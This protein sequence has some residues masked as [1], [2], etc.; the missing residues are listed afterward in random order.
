MKNNKILLLA[1]LLHI[2]PD[3]ATRPAMPEEHLS[4]GGEFSRGHR[5]R[6]EM[7]YK[8]SKELSEKESENFQKRE[9]LR[10]EQAKEKQDPNSEIKNAVKE[11]L[12]SIDSEKLSPEEIQASLKKEFNVTI[13]LSAADTPSIAATQ[14]EV[15][16]HG[17]DKRALKKEHDKAENDMKEAHSA[18]KDEFEKTLADINKTKSSED[19]IKNTT[20]EQADLDKF[21]KTEVKERLAQ[22]E[23]PKQDEPN[24][25]EEQDGFVTVKESL[26]KQKQQESKKTGQQEAF[27]KIDTI[28]EHFNRK[29]YKKAKQ[30]SD[31]FAEAIKDNP[32]FTQKERDKLS[33]FIKETTESLYTEPG[34]FERFLK[35]LRNLIR[36]N[37]QL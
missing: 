25:Q 19:V 17:Q 24:E 3:I 36:K 1:I 33:D 18:L 4:G 2:A 20:D 13:Q 37:P 29:D 31:A 9:E 26:P 30:E 6:A 23:A 11:H 34:I 15:L 28:E 21:Y 5:E 27:K 8:H 32:R 12:K 7:K 35:F 10:R 14:V 16:K 22:K